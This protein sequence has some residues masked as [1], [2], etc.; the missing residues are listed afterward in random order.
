VVADLLDQDVGRRLAKAWAR[1]DFGTYYHRGLL[2]L[3]SL[4]F[5]ALSSGPEHPL[6]AALAAEAPEPASVTAAAVTAAFARDRPRSHLWH[7]LTRREVQTNEVS[8]A[9]AWLWPAALAAPR[10]VAIA[11]VGASAGLN[12]VADAILDELAW[13]TEEGPLSVRPTPPILRRVGFD[14]QPLDVEQ[15]EDATWLRACIWAGEQDRLRRLDAAIAAF[16]AARR[17]GPPGAPSTGLA[18]ETVDIIDV[19]ARLTAL[20]SALREPIWLAYQTVVREYLGDSFE[21]FARGMREWLAGMPAG[22]AVWL[23]LETAEAGGSRAYPAA[24][25]AH[26]RRPD[27]S[28]IDALLARCDYHPRHLVLEPSAVALLRDALAASG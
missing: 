16:R 1:R 5:D 25:T 9:V 17:A 11:D 18:V 3:A 2:L 15:D 26:L 8:R 23:E 24:L 19:P 21:P 27:G 14:R 20:S 6:W 13:E 7:A 10:P 28:A 12:L 4:R 22:R